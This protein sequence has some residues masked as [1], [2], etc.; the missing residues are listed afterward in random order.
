[1]PSKYSHPEIERRWLVETTDGLQLSA[2][3]ARTIEDKYL[4]GSRL[5]LRKICEQSCPPVFKLGKK[6]EHT[7]SEPES[8]VN[9]YLSE[10]EYQSLSVLPGRTTTKVRY[11]VEGGALDVYEAPNHARV[12]FEMEFASCEAAAMYLAPGFVGTEVTADEKYTGFALSGVA[13]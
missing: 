4:S 2:V 11:S 13:V 5:R 7:E 6:Y 10:A 1:M 9:I 8:V 12:I 3:R